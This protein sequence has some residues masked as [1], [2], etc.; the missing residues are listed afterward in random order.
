M[1]IQ[2]LFSGI[3]RNDMLGMGC[4]KKIERSFS[5]FDY[6][7]KN[8]D[9]KSSNVN[10]YHNEVVKLLEECKYKNKLKDDSKKKW[11]DSFPNIDIDTILKRQIESFL[12]GTDQ[13][14][15][16]GRVTTFSWKEL[17]LFG[18]LLLEV[19]Y[20]YFVGGSSEEC[21]ALTKC[22]LSSDY[23]ECA[24]KGKE[25]LTEPVDLELRL[26][27]PPDPSP[28]SDP[29]LGL[30]EDFHNETLCRGFLSSLIKDLKY[31]YAKT[32]SSS[33]SPSDSKWKKAILQ[34]TKDKGSSYTK[35]VSI[36]NDLEKRGAESESFKEIL[37]ILE[38]FS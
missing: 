17:F 33:V 2:F 13:A 30:R 7:Q 15:G 34:L 24:S 28:I 4:N 16:T 27:P 3:S 22:I 21:G 31:L 14:T 6:Q 23:V 20:H 32:A 1:Y 35:Y 12:N 5:S 11:K 29:A 38:E 25:P 19:I 9:K 26:G 8:L 37:K 36:I 10:L 18:L